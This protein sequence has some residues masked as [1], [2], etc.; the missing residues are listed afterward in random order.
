MSKVAVIGNATLIAYEEDC[1]I[2]AS[3]PWFGDEDH[4]YFG[5]WILTHEIPAKYKKD[6]LNSKY[7]WFSHGHPD[8]LNPISLKRFKGKQILLPD[9]V[10][11]RIFNELSTKNYDV[12]IL[13]DRKWVE[14][15]ENIR[16]MCITTVIQD[17]ILLLEINNR[18]FINLN[19]AGTKGCTGF[20]RKIVKD[21]ENS[22]LLSLSGYGDADMIN[23][24][25]KNGEFIIPPAVNNL[26][27][28]EQLSL[29]AKSIG[30]NHVIPFSSHHQYQRSDSIWA[31]EYVTPL[32]AYKDGIF[33]DINF[34]P[35]FSEINCFTGDINEINPSKISVNIRPPK[36]FGDNWSDQLEKNDL[37]TIEKYF[38]EKELLRKK[39]GFIEFIVGSKRHHINLNNKLSSGIAFEVPR[40]S[41]MKAINYEIFDDLLIGNFMKTYLID[42]RSLYESNFN[43]IVTK[44]SDNGRAKTEEE[45]SKYIKEYKKRIGRAFIYESFLDKS[46]SIVNRFFIDRGSNVR[47]KL[48][49]I[50]YKIK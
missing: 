35:A 7:L 44:Y 6:I 33:E 11:S 26:F 5:S 47:R 1:P 28:G 50:Y 36:D 41:L 17:S 23:C 43:Y 15:S 10:G 9:H 19:D 4:A 21:Y 32:N 29:V 20:V 40:G 45:V 49:Q 22:Y 16:I 24:Y 39:I 8:H 48:K 31:Q 14:I 2:I 18:V 27:V 25:D 37:N 42:T 46:A 30:A 34:I 3:D 38:K 13:P 12:K